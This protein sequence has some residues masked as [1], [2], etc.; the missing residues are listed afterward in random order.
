MKYL[1]KQ[2]KAGRN[3][4]VVVNFDHPAKVML[5]KDSEYRKY[6]DG[7]TYNYRGG[8]AENSPVKF[9]LPEGATWHVVVEKGSYF[10]PISIHASVQ[11][12]PPG[13]EAEASGFGSNGSSSE[14]KVISRLEKLLDEGEE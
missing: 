14:N 6:K 7:Q 8:F 4:I 10:N 13:S 3:C 2:L 5:L 1:H 12:L 11:V 9:V